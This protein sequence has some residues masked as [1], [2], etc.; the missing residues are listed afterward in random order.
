MS[1]RTLFGAAAFGKVTQ[2]EADATMDVLM[3]YGVN[4]IDTA[5]SYGDSE[6]RLGPWMKRYRNYFFLAT[7]TG[8][9][10]KQKAWDEIRRSLD[11]LQTDY[12]DL[13]QLHNLNNP[14]HWQTAMGADGA[15]EAC[16]EAKAQGL[17][18]YIGVTGHEVVVAGMHERSLNH[19]DFDAVLL[20]YNYLMMQNPVYAMAFE[21]VYAMCKQRNVAVQTIKSIVRRRYLTEHR[22][23][24][25]WYEPLTD[26]ADLDLAVSW[27]LSRPNVFLNTA[28]DVSI[29]PKVLNAAE[30]F[31]NGN[32]AP[33]SSADMQAMVDRLTMTPM[34]W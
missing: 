19:F 15:L 34:F 7:K 8:E 12:V 9:R 6:L 25:T 13:I 10:T 29:L 16:L 21:Q 17:V 4:H 1:T 5:A 33:P 22:T 11:R 26:Q 30:R 20:P 3:S 27:V 28:G 24:A 32:I 23:H 2:A 31:T 14:E 18:R